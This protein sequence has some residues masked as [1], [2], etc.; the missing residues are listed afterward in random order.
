LGLEVFL[1]SDIEADAPLVPQVVTLTLIAGGRLAV[2]G[3]GAVLDIAFKIQVGGGL[4]LHG[5]GDDE[6]DEEV[7]ANFH[8]VAHA[9]YGLGS[10]VLVL[11]RQRSRLKR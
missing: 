2:G 1:V 6:V 7:I 11:L 3:G 5:Q 8:P 9:H 4:V 10:T